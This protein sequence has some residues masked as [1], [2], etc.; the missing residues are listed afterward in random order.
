MDLWLLRPGH[1]VRT[2]EGMEAE[3]LSGTEG[4]NGS[5]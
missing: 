1:K 2:L 5:G 3:I 4:G